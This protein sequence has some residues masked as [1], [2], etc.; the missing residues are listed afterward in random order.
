MRLSDYLILG[1]MIIVPITFVII[2]VQ[3][4]ILKYFIRE[5]V[6][7]A[8]TELEERKNRQ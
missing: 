4:I 8:L 7:E 3:G 5:A 1:F 6:K 2:Y